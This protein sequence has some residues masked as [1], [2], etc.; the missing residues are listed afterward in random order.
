MLYLLNKNAFEINKPKK[1]TKRCFDVLIDILKYYP[2]SFVYVLCTCTVHIYS[3]QIHDRWLIHNII[4]NNIH[5][6]MQ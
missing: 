6:P 3:L 4:D 1:S 5:E 2:D